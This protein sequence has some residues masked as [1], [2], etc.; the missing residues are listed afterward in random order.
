MPPELKYQITSLVSMH[1][2]MQHLKS[3]GELK[4]MD[5]A[6]LDPETLCPRLPKSDQNWIY[7]HKAI[8]LASKPYEGTLGCYKS[9]TELYC[10]YNECR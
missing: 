6:W 8:E 3:S 1:F 7:I 2:S 9:I 10:Q 4:D 5:P